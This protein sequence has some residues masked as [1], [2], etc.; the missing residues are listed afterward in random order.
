M[1]VFS[2]G[3]DILYK[4]SPKEKM[5]TFSDSV[6]PCFENITLDRQFSIF[7]F[8]RIQMNSV[9]L[10][11]AIF[12][13]L[14]FTASNKENDLTTS[15]HKVI[16]SNKTNF[17]FSLEKKLAYF[18]KQHQQ[19]QTFSSS[20]LSSSSVISPQAFIQL[21]EEIISLKFRFLQD[22]L[23]EDL[24]SSVK[25]VHHDPV[26]KT[27]NLIGLLE[28][29]FFPAMRLW[30]KKDYLTAK[31][32]FYNA[33]VKLKAAFDEETERSSSSTTNSTIPTSIKDGK[34]LGYHVYLFKLIIVCLLLNND[35]FA[36]SSSSTISTNLNTLMLTPSLYGYQNNSS[37]VAGTGGGGG[38]FGK[39]GEE[40][41]LLIKTTTTELLPSLTVP[42]V[43]LTTSMRHEK[44]LQ[45]IY[46]FWFCLITKRKEIDFS[47]KYHYEMTNLG[48]NITTI[49]L[50]S[51]GIHLLNETTSILS[52]LFD[53]YH[54]FQLLFPTFYA[55]FF[56][57]QKYHSTV[58]AKIKNNTF[59]SR[60]LTMKEKTLQ[61]HIRLN[62]NT[63]LSSS[64]ILSP[65]SP[66][67]PLVTHS[68]F[69]PSSLSA[70]ANLHPSSSPPAAY[71]EFLP[72]LQSKR[73][74]PMC[75][76]SNQ[77]DNKLSTARPFIFP[78]GK[79]WK[80]TGH[81]DHITC[82]TVYLGYLFTGS[83]DS[84]IK[85]WNISSIPFPYHPILS[86][87][88]HKMGITC[89]FTD[90]TNGY[91][92]TGSDD[93]Y[94]AIWD[95]KGILKEAREEGSGGKG[96]RKGHKIQPLM[97]LKGHKD[98]ISTMIF[99]SPLMFPS[100]VSN[101][102]ISQK[103]HSK[104]ENKTE[105]ID[106]DD[107]NKVKGTDNTM[108]MA[109]DGT[110][111]TVETNQSEQVGILSAEPKEELKS[112]VEESKSVK[113][114]ER[115]KRSDTKNQKNNKKENESDHELSPYYL[116]SGSADNTIIIWNIPKREYFFPSTLP[117]SFSSDNVGNLS[118]KKKKET[119]NNRT[120]GEMQSGNGKMHSVDA[121]I[122]TKSV[123]ISLL[124]TKPPSPTLPAPP[125]L[126]LSS[127]FAASPISLPS[128]SH[129]LKVNSHPV[130]ILDD[131]KNWITCLVISVEKQLLFSGSYDHTIKV[132]DIMNLVPIT[133]DEEG[134]KDE[135]EDEEDNGY[136]HAEIPCL[137][138][139]SDHQGII[140]QLLIS[141]DRLY[142]AAGDWKI[143]IWDIS[144][145]V[146][147]NSSV[148]TPSPLPTETSKRSLVSLSSP[149]VVTKEGEEEGKTPGRERRLSNTSTKAAKRKKKERERRQGG[150]SIQPIATLW[151]HRG[152]VTTML[153]SLE[154]GILI[155]SSLDRTILIW[156]VSSYPVP[157]QP[158][159]RLRGC[160]EAVNR[161]VL[162]KN[163]L[164]ANDKGNN[165]RIWD[166]SSL[167]AAAMMLNQ[168]QTNSSFQHQGEK[169][170]RE[171]TGTK[172]GS[173]R[174]SSA[175]HL[176]ISSPLQSPSVS[177]QQLISSNPT[178]MQ[179]STVSIAKSTD[180]SPDFFLHG[181]QEKK[182]M[183]VLKGS[184]KW[185]P[186]GEGRGFICTM[187]V[188][189]NR[190]I[191]STSDNTIQI[192]CL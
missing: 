47:L 80:G 103:I 49:P 170:G 171:T 48:R 29:E 45:E 164:I 84:T 71:Y 174:P 179:P 81:E 183:K 124:P 135:E 177:H 79:E 30:I 162:Y 109:E 165:L 22:L 173:I 152:W 108:L 158:I 98:W 168:S 1:P 31:N 169:G 59:S 56:S 53:L 153:L 91:L 42:Q 131:H 115:N 181:I 16:N 55:S 172:A 32:L 34:G 190:L 155:T 37:T 99:Y 151:G 133:E 101:N 160:K 105:E 187:I 143:K 3:E 70:A 100:A 112:P 130:A 24:K 142:S 83:K 161:M 121:E 27:E 192:R 63:I 78:S 88:Y 149:W 93:S 117:Y 7:N 110:T 72:L 17:S 167:N 114:D 144:S 82:S 11:E 97:V 189:H 44:I 107:S 52:S 163:R 104:E 21:E 5:K 123:D 188:V 33:L 176:N 14:F 6:M 180:V 58:V 102:G 156:D 26:G 75:Y 41:S 89:M 139:L 19:Q 20:F 76:S 50:F 122:A 60:Q 120:N 119:E 2:I 35:Y 65:S 146:T 182:C 191:T 69:D 57:Y 184:S 137:V 138:T 38:D 8:I 39:K 154:Y 68:P 128:T 106:N 43:S 92:F 36:T 90:S 96:E 186:G 141:E 157:L 111:L 64:P 12:H 87:S 51:P 145:M 132:W 40:P 61:E 25:P 125:A 129:I 94:I 175:S 46:P 4:S 185:N 127:P 95:C 148:A 67:S 86:L 134:T 140:K 77:Y 147:M 18:K 126:A 178:L 10:L 28:N 85:V 13:N 116:I 66:S 73:G 136:Y 118:Q 159:G 150:W 62:H 54:S 15:C 113:F 166:I 74:Y 9:L 23:T